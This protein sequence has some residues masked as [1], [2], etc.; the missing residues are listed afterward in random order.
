MCAHA[1]VM[2]PLGVSVAAFSNGINVAALSG[3][4]F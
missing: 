1:G 3:I 4:F 2:L